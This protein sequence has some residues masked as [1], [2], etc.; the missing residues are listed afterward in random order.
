MRHQIGKSDWRG[1]EI[2]TQ[3]FSILTWTNLL[4]RAWQEMRKWKMLRLRTGTMWR[5]WRTRCRGHSTWRRRPR[6]LPGGEGSSYC[7]YHDHWPTPTQVWFHPLHGGQRCGAGECLEVPVH[8][9]QQRRRGLPHPLL[10]LHV[11]HLVFLSF[12]LFVIWAFCLFVFLIPYFM[13]RFVVGISGI[14]IESTMGQYS[15]MGTAHAFSK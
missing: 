9:V 12:C 1:T 4:P 7:H 8:G 13:Y 14:L 3:H 6:G 5:R 11:C 2:H 15:A 10:H